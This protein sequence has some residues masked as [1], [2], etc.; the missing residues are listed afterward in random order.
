[1][2]VVETIGVAIE[3]DAATPSRFFGLMKSQDRDI[4]V[5]QGVSFDHLMTWKQQYGTDKN[6][7]E[8]Q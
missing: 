4:R 5:G 6:L 7:A 8:F 1:M 2:A 3:G